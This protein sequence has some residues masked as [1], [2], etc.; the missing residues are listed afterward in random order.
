MDEKKRFRIEKE[1]NPGSDWALAIYSTLRR[2]FFSSFF[3]DVRSATESVVSFKS[4]HAQ[5]RQ[6]KMEKK[7]QTDGFVTNDTYDVTKLI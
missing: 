3:A 2:F 6:G 5:Q 1:V 7:I 4:T